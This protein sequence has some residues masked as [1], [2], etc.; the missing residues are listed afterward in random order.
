MHSHPLLS[1]LVGKSFMA[2]A[3][4]YTLFPL[5]LFS[6]SEGRVGVGLYDGLADLGGDDEAVLLDTKDVGGFFDGRKGV[7]PLRIKEERNQDKNYSGLTNQV[8]YGGEVSG[9]VGFI[10]LLLSDPDV[11]VA[12][13]G[14]LYIHIKPISALKMV[15]EKDAIEAKEKDGEGGV[16]L[17]VVEAEHGEFG[18]EFAIVG[19]YG[20][21]RRSMEKQER[22]NTIEIFE[23]LVDP[24]LYNFRSQMTRN[25]WKLNGVY[26]LYSI[27]LTRYLMFLVPGV[28]P[29]AVGARFGE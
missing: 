20:V 13:D 14:S 12:T 23:K 22:R 4:S 26:R 18:E 27:T 7:K 8:V 11:Y 21:R 15:R 1:H 25:E 28:L 16:V 10:I 9:T 6:M 17:V 29:A 19:G 24:T 2:C 3:S 5:H